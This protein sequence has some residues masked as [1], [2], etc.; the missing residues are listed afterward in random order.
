MELRTK[1][2]TP[3]RNTIFDSLYRPVDL[4]ENDVNKLAIDQERR[5]QE[6]ARCITEE[7]KRWGILPTPTPE[8]TAH[9]AELPTN[10]PVGELAVAATVAR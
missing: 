7:E 9:Q 1:N 6:V 4:V 3:P 2:L 8:E 5:R 10:Q